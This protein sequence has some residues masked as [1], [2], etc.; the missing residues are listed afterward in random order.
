MAAVFGPNVL[1]D[2]EI[3]VCEDN[4]DA[5]EMYA[6]L[7]ELYGAKV[8]TAPSGSTGWETFQAHRPDLVIS[9]LQ[10]PDGDGYELVRRIRALPAE[11]GGLT[12]AIAVSAADGAEAMAVGFHAHLVKPVDP[13]VLVD[14]VR[15]FVREGADEQ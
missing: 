4:D 10:M 11:A 5:R 12:P 6:V 8:V 3:L 1:S 13:L 15:G 2:V 9:D 14:V 7:F